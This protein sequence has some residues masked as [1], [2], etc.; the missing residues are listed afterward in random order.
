MVYPGYDAYE[1][2]LQNDL[3]IKDLQGNNYMGMVWPG[4]TYFPDFLNPRAQDYW[5]EQLSSF[6]S[7]VN[8]DGIWIDMNE[9]SNFCN[10]DGNAQVCTSWDP[11][12][13]DSYGCC[14]QCST[15]DPTNSLDF[16]KYHINHMYG[17]LSTKTIAMS[18]QHYNNA[19]VYNMHNLYGLMEQIASNNAMKSIRN[20]RPFVLS[21]SSFLSTGVHSA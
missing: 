1:K 20:K 15:V 11:N 4:Q 17:K 21:R 7:L 8:N 18:N 13:C 12:H 10:Q 6:Y 14:V 3:F 19:T 16:P 9:I 2:G 5:T